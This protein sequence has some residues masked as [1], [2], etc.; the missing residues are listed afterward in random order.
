MFS[1]R[2]AWQA[3]LLPVVGLVVCL[4]L[5]APPKRSTALE[6]PQLPDAEFYI[7]INEWEPVE[8][9]PRQ[10]GSWKDGW[11][12]FKRLDLHDTASVEREHEPIEVDVEFHAA[13]LTSLARE[14]RVA[15]VETESGPIT[16]IPSQVYNEAAD[17]EARRGRIVFLASLKPDE[18]KTYLIFYGNSKCPPPEYE[19]DL[20]VT[21]QGYAIDVENRYYKVILAKT[22]GHLKGL[23]FKQGKF[24]HNS[25]GPPGGHGVEG[26]M[27]W[28]PDWSDAHTGRYRVTNWPRPPHYNVARGPVCVRLT[29][30]GHPILALGPS[31]GQP[32]KVMATVTYVFYASVP[33]IL[34][35]SRLDVLEDVRFR[36]CR[37]DEWV[38]VGAGLPRIAWMMKDGQIG[39]STYEKGMG[40]EREDPVWMTYFNKETSEAFGSIHVEYECT[41]PRWNVPSSVGIG[42]NLWVRYPL[43]N[44][45][46]RKGDFVREKN[47]YLVHKYAPPNQQGFGMLMNHYERLRRPLDQ[48]DV[49]FAKKRLSKAAVLDALRACYD[50]EVYVSG[51]S[52][53][54][55]RKLSI[56]DLGF[57]YDVK[58]S[59]DD[60]HVAMT[61]P[62][63]GRAGWFVWFE[64]MIH[65][66][67][68]Q[69]IDAVG[70]IEVKLVWEPPWGSEKLTPRA[71][72]RLGLLHTASDSR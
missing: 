43:Q 72:R 1:N 64:K 11:K 23:S 57:V 17:A 37:N 42:G 30:W 27:H 66:Q 45:N 2:T 5:L 48:P 22:M 34:M 56:V 7:P 59:G 26:T 53:A 3:V 40:W 10:W 9:L 31:V 20:K 14:V 47:A 8:A 39:F 35:E 54:A 6:F 61:M 28:N 15:V 49:P 55:K 60:L 13:H 24:S 29:R 68:N 16:E 63:K 19:T 51:R 71:K 46:M 41:H 4:V 33:Y 58:V 52:Y 62:Y 65:K 50:T 44:A 70:K 21:G 69:R 18:K 38:G 32:Q 36:D 25:G 12:C 67:I